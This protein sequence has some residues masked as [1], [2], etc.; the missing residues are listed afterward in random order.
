M[1]VLFCL[2]NL[3]PFVEYDGYYALSELMGE[4]GFGINAR[5]NILEPGQ[6]KIEYVLYFA[7]SQ[8]F[9]LAIIFLALTGLQ[10]LA[11]RFTH[12]G[13]INYACV[14]CMIIAYFFFARRTLR[15]V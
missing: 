3:V 2:I 15:K 8:I 7:L 1:N 12:G 6:K 13:W 5:R 11:L 10:Q 14:A 4:P 9:A